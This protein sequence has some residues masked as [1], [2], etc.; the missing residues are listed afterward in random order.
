[1][2]EN[3]GTPG[4]RTESDSFGPIEVEASR[5]W[6]AQTQRSLQNFRIGGS[7]AAAADPGAGAGQAGGRAGQSRARA[8]STRSARARSSQAADEVI[9]GR[10]RRSIPARRLADRLGHAEQYER[11]RG[12]R[13]PRQRVARRRRGGKSPVHPNDH[14]NWAS[15][16]T[17]RFPTAIHV[18]AALEI[19]AACCPRSTRCRALSRKAERIR[20]HRQDRPH[21]S[22]GRDADDAGPGIFRLCRAMSLGAVAHPRHPA[23]PSALAQGGTAVGTGLNAHA[24]FRRGFRAEMAALTGLPFTSAANKFEALASHDAMVVAMARSTRSPRPVQDR[25]R[26][27]PAG[28]RPALGPRRIVAAGER[29]RL[30][31][32]AGQGQ[33]DAGRSADHGLRPRHSAMRRRSRSPVRRGIC[34]LNVFKPVIAYALFESFRCSAMPRRA[35]A[36]IASKASRP[37]RAHC[38]TGRALADAGDGARAEDRL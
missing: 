34:E 28:Q 13:Q 29:A 24:G 3:A 21:A 5:Y 27:S 15:P 32:H 38:G 33:S 35:S 36:C 4:S 23:G 12:D 31:D 14:V 20:R 10:A 25:Q 26:H 17:I 30:L 9:A 8:V 7:H 6:G 22:A 1:M 2:A 16:P 37:T 18:A 11:Q 19:A